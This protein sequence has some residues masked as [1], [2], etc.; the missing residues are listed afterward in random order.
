MYVEIILLK[1]DLSRNNLGLV[2]GA[3]FPSEVKEIRDK[4]NDIPI[5]MPGLGFQGGNFKGA[6]NSAKGKPCQGITIDHAST[7]LS[8]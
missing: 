2:V 4:N 5:L 1:I 6:I 8:L 3:T 7:H